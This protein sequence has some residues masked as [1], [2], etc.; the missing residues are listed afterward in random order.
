MDEYIIYN[1][2]YRV[3][4]CRQHGY[5]IAPDYVLRHFRNSHKTIPLETRQEIAEYAQSLILVS[6]ENVDIPRDMSNPIDGLT[7]V[8]GFKCS[9][10]QCRELR[11]TLVSVQK[12]CNSIHGWDVSQGIMWREKLLQ[13]FFQGSNRKYVSTNVC[14]LIVDTLQSQLRW[15]RK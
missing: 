14:V 15:R 8:N 13:T 9:Y 7:I 10:I 2:R 12:H 1:T 3:A 6:P 4:I 5:A 11:G